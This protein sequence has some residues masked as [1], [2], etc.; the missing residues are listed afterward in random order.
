MISLGSFV[1]QDRPCS[2]L[3]NRAARMQY[4]LV[5]QLSAAEYS[6]LMLAGWRR[7]GK[8]L[9]RPICVGCNECKALRVDVKRFRANQ[10]QKRCRKANKDDVKLVIGTPEVTAEKLALYDRYHA[11][12]IQAK[13]WAD[14]GPEA[15]A[16]YVDAF[17][18]QPFAVQE[19]C[20]RLAGELVGVGYV[21]DVPAGLSAIYFF[22]APEHR[23]RGL[24][25]FNVLSI[26][27]RAADRGDDFAYLGYYV[28]DCG[29]LV[30]KANFRPN[31]IRND[32]DTWSVLRA[33]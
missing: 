15:E 29:S 7:F 22:H 24:G 19:W 32:D 1:S 5:A 9:F 12:Q 3:P 20:Y 10:S 8:S 6:R 26:I 30:Y 31:Q 21:D 17:V 14:R 28:E 11:F 18:D 23:D 33:D 16:N 25:T 2:Y 27:D 4:E 13:G